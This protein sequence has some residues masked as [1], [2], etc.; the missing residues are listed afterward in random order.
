MFILGSMLHMTIRKGQ[1]NNSA[2]AQP[3]PVLTANEHPTIP[4]VRQLVI[5]AKLI[6]R[7]K[8]EGGGG[9]GRWAF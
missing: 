5:E 2:R 3:R 4:L 8:S 9:E 6:F 7:K 1:K